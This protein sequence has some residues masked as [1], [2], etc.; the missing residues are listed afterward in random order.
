MHQSDKNS[1]DSISWFLEE[2]QFETIREAHEWVYSGA[3]NEIGYLFDGYKTKDSK[4][5]Y[6]LL[7]ELVRLNTFHG[8]RQD[9]YCDQEYL[10]GSMI[11]K[12]WVKNKAYDFP[13]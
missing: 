13:K 8:H 3:Y 10:A 5:A 4:L 9:V 12:V 2:K 1:E 7:F 6:A 11:Y